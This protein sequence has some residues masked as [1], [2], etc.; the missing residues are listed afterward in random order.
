MLNVNKILTKNE[1][2]MKRKS[3]SPKKKGTIT[4]TEFAAQTKIA[5]FLSQ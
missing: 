1:E 5:K 3:Q 4:F 2:V